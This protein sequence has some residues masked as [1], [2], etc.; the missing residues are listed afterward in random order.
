MLLNELFN[1]KVDIKDGETMWKKTFEVNGKT[2]RCDFF[3]GPRSSE[4]GPEFIFVLNGKNNEL[5]ITNTGD[6]LEVF[7]AVIK[8]MKEFMQNSNN[9]RYY[10]TAEM[11]EPSRVKLYDR[12]VKRLTKDVPGWKCDSWNDKY[13]RTYALE[14]EGLDD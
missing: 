8:V 2:Y 3:G 13:S 9:K 14:R 4:Y 6:E 7:S 5:G 10:F 11:S 12:L 1:T